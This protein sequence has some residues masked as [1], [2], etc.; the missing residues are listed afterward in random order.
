MARKKIPENYEK[1]KKLIIQSSIEVM[2]NKNIAQ[3]SLQDVADKVGM[4]KAG[5]YWY[6]PN[7]STLIEEVAQYVYDTYIRRVQS[8]A[9][10]KLG[11]SEKIRTIILGD[12]DTIEA[13]IMCVFPLKM[14]LDSLGQE[15]EIKRLIKDGYKIYNDIMTALINEGIR[16]GEFQTELP[17]N[18]L[19]KYI[20]GS[21]DGLAMQNLLLSTEKIE[22]SR[23]TLAAIIESILKPVRKGDV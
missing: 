5:I 4:T 1:T 20:T 2:V 21:I 9:E 17:V 14:F 13:A 11:V 10:S 23:P 12:E 15:S 7:K 16:T 22:I 3:F 6:F 18:E 8:I 19:A